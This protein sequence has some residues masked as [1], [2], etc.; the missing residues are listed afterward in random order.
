MDAFALGNIQ[1]MA[2][3]D[4]SVP[5]LS[6]IV[7]FGTTPAGD[8]LLTGDARGDHILSGLE[9][10]GAIAKD[11]PHRL[12]LLKVQH[13]G[14]DRNVTK[15]YFE[16]LPADICLLSANGKHGNPDQEVL[17]M[18]VDVAKADQRK[19]IIVVTNEA[20]S[21]G[22]LRQNRPPSQFDYSLIV[23]DP[24]R[25]AVVIDLVAGSVV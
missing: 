23:R 12:R 19:P 16:R 15:N 6:S 2:N 7:L 1:A 10:S 22:W 4:K 24:A 3:A 21:L 5:N 17:A 11:A 25:H 20:P 13:H 8:I 14:S 18:I 9:Q